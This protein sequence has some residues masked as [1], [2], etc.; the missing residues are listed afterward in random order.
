MK[1]S[2][3]Q[4]ARR[5]PARGY[6][7]SEA[8][9]PAAFEL[10]YD[11]YYLPFVVARHDERA[12]VRE[13]P[14]LRRHFG[15]G[16]VVWISKDDKEVAGVLYPLHGRGPSLLG[17]GTLGGSPRAHPPRGVGAGE[18]FGGWLCPRGRPGLG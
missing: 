11:R 14:I 10:F 18:M 17:R 5:L 7:W 16:G 6:A 8:H 2:T 13:R 15:R 3:R 12:I 9:D 4:T 1:H